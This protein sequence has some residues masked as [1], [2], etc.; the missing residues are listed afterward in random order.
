MR[1]RHFGAALLAIGCSWTTVVTGPAQTLP[2]GA[3][4]MQ[5]THGDWRVACSQPGGKTVCNMSQQ[6]ADKDSRQLVLAI[7]L[8]A[9]STSRAEGRLVLPFGVALERGVTL[10]IDDAPVQTLHFRTCLPVG[11]LVALNFDGATLS[12]LRKGTVLTVKAT[13]DGGQETAFKI[14]LNGFAGALDRTATLSR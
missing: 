3:S 7:E 9:V 2:G 10:Q 4:S 6:Y 11:C 12:S 5:E 8:N 13:A 1:V 14:S